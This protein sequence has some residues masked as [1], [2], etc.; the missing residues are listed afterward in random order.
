MALISRTASK[1]GLSWRVACRSPWIPSGNL[2]N[3]KRRKNEQACFRR[4]SKKPR[5]NVFW[6]VWGCHVMYP[7]RWHVNWNGIFTNINDTNFYEI[8]STGKRFFNSPAWCRCIFSS[9]RHF[10]V[11]RGQRHHESIRFCSPFGSAGVF[12]ALLFGKIQSFG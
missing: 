3:S 1:S 4:N 10:Y 7:D 5:K 8:K 2:I 9:P 12:D 6:L 11:I